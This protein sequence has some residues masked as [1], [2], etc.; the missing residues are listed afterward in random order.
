[1]AAEALGGRRQRA[2]HACDENLRRGHGRWAGP[3]GVVRPAAARRAKPPARHVPHAIPGGATVA[4]PRQGPS[5]PGVV[6]RCTAPPPRGAPGNGGAREHRAPAD[7]TPPA[8]EAAPAM[9][10]W[11]TGV[12]SPRGHARERR[13]A[14]P[15][16]A[17]PPNATEAV[18]HA[19]TRPASRL[20]QWGGGWRSSTA[21][22]GQARAGTSSGRRGRS[23]GA[24]LA[25]R[26]GALRAL[27]APAPWGREWQRRSAPA[28]ALPR[29]PRG[30]R[31]A[32]CL[33]RG[34]RRGAPAGARASWPPGHRRASPPPGRR[35]SGGGPP[36][37]PRGTPE[38][39]PWVRS[40]ARELAPLMAHMGGERA[41]WLEGYR[42]QMVD[43]N[44]LEASEHRLQARARPPGAPCLANRW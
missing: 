41:P 18:G 25:P 13:R 26:L 39:A 8:P 15:T 23:T 31:A 2:R 24:G 3:A 6:P 9:V 4:R 12:W 29:R 7:R 34:G 17:P 1:M 30:A 44:C 42:I 27:G 21:A 38:H 14:R 40:S 43:G 37:T 36:R 32:A 19:P 22:G 28:R 33:R 11:R 16:H 20:P 10:C 35:G 5:G